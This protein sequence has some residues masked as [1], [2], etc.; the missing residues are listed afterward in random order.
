MAELAKARLEEMSPGSQTEEL[1]PRFS[2][3]PNPFNAETQIRYHLP[4]DS[5]V[6]IK[7]YNALGQLTRTLINEKQFSGEHVLHWNGRGN[8]GYEV[9]SGL[10]FCRLVMRGNAYTQKLVML[11]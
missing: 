5:E 4:E 9:A 3:Y 1:S 6:V 11:K 2:I 7:I 8:D 10:Y